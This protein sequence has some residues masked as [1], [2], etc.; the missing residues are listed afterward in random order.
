MMPSKI[1]EYLI[2]FTE[3][4]EGVALMT[5]EEIQAELVA[6]GYDVEAGR[7]ALRERLDAASRSLMCPECLRPSGIRIEDLPDYD[8]YALVACKRGECRIRSSVA[9]WAQGNGYTARWE[10]PDPH[11]L[12]DGVPLSDYKQWDIY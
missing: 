10:R 7:L 9:Q 11:E 4:P 2:Q 6:E 5:P 12:V 3:D 8:C 1:L